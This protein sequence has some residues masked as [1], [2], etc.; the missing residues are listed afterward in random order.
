MGEEEGGGRKE[1]RAPILEELEDLLGM[2]R[3][4]RP[5][6]V[7]FQLVGRLGRD[8]PGLGFRVSDFIVMYLV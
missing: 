5:A 2:E 3:V 8:V 6:W 4:R 1:G 7:S